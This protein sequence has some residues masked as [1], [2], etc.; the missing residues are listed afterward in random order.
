MPA[1]ETVLRSGATAAKDFTLHDEGRS[2][3]VAE[4]MVA[5]VGKTI[6]VAMAL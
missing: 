1:I 3:R 6:L 2:F 4:R 5:V